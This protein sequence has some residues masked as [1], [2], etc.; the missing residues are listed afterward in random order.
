[1]APWNLVLQ[2]VVAWILVAH[3]FGIVLWLGGLLMTTVLLAQ[4]ARETSPEARAALTRLEKKS[5]RAMA[6]PGALIA[7]LAG[8]TLILSNPPYYV[9]ATWLHI[10]LTLV[11]AMIIL[12]GFIGIEMKS[13]QKG[14]TAMTSGKAWWLFGG[15]LLIFLCILIATLPGEVYM[16]H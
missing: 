5:M 1:M 13:L 9:H 6:D 2:R 15:V 4:H 3:V 12:H 11:V 8:V 10:K 7:I 14:V 16:A